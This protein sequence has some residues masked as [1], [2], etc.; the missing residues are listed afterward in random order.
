VSNDRPLA[1][2]E[3]ALVDELL[4]LRILSLGEVDALDV[5]ELRELA[6]IALG[7]ALRSAA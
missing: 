3:S 4:R 2:W 6:L 5:G 1:R 7:S